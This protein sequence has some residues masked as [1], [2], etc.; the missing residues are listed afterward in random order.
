MLARRPGPEAQLNI[1]NEF[2]TVDYRKVGFWQLV[3]LALLMT[4]VTQAIHEGGHWVVYEG[5]G[6]GPVWS[7]T[8]LVQTWE[9]P[10]LHP[11]GWIETTAPDGTPGWWRLQSA[12]SKT[13][14]IIGLTAGPLASVLS[15]I[16]G[17]SLTLTR[18][19]ISPFTKQAGLVLALITSLL[20]SQ[21][22]LRGFSRVGGDEYFIAAYLGIPKYIVDSPFTLAF[23]TGFIL[24]LRALGDRRTMLKWLGAIVLGSTP[25]GLFLMYANE[26]VQSQV[27]QG[28]PLFQPLL[29]F[30]LPVMIV[31]TTAL[32]ALWIW[33]KRA[34]DQYYTS[35]KTSG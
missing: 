17:L 13:E 33:W 18:L 11:D 35:M 32:L 7:F 26:V 28:N 22:Y 21:Y 24:C 25:A 20:M 10:P 30:S 14:N 29:G 15:V 4:V 2:Q 3:I 8:G 6:K 1:R 16:F 12:P 31:N 23:I 5:L 34:S 19:K 27:D 9:T